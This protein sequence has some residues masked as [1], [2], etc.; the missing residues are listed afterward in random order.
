MKSFYAG[1]SLIQ[2][3]PVQTVTKIRPSLRYKLSKY[4][5]VDKLAIC[6]QPGFYLYRE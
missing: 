2:Q 3:I 1:D 4:T 5:N 6:V